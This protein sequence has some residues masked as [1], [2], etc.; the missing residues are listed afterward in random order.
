MWRGRYS[1]L[2]ET[3][4]GVCRATHVLREIGEAAERDKDR[5][6]EISKHARTHTLVHASMREIGQ[7]HAR[8]RRL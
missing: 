4:V 5:Q 6:N 7:D 8:E 2:G 1:A 3:R